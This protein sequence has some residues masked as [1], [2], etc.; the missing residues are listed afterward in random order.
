MA[1]VIANRYGVP[2]L[3]SS[4][5]SPITDYPY[6]QT[7]YNPVTGAARLSDVVI[8]MLNTAAYIQ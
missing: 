6:S 1:V 4:P 3:L 5:G 2:L 8:R 7:F